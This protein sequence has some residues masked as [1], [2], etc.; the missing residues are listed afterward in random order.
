MIV[1][2]GFVDLKAQHDSTIKSVNVLY[3]RPFRDSAHRS[4]FDFI[5]FILPY[6]SQRFAGTTQ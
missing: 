6:P 4:R 1:L 3:E 5:Y 2:N